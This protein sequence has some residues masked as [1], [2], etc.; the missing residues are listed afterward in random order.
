[1]K[2]IYCCQFKKYE[3]VLPKVLE[4]FTGHKVGDV[5]EMHGDEWKIE[6]VIL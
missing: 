6:D 5:I 4:V 3:A 2:R 1:M